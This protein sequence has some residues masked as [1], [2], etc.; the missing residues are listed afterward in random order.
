MFL[1]YHSDMRDVTRFDAD[2]LAHLDGILFPENALNETTLAN[3]VNHGVGW[4]IEVAG[5]VVAYALARN[6]DDLLDLLR[7]GV[8]PDYQ[9]SGFGTQLLQRLLQENK[10]AM[11][12][13]KKSNVGA[14][15]LYVKHGFQIVGHLPANESWV[16]LR[17]VTAPASS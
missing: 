11:L 9:H 6:S 14:I 3:E 7:L 1:L 16:M 10:K 13:V 5:D 2:V 17:K 8:H 4:V 15:R 12:T